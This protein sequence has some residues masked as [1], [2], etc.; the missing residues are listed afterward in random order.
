M[1]CVSVPDKAGVGHVHRWGANKYTVRRLRSEPWI[2]ANRSNVRMISKRTLWLQPDDNKDDTMI[3]MLLCSFKREGHPPVPE[4]LASSI[5]GL[6][7]L[8][9]PSNDKRWQAAHNE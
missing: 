3:M 4:R 9:I 8:G 5:S 2:G 1:G 7:F 6:E